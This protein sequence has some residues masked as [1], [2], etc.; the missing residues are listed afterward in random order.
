MSFKVFLNLLTVSL[1]VSCLNFGGDSSSSGSNSNNTI[2]T[3]NPKEILSTFKGGTVDIR[4]T[5][6][7]KISG[8]IDQKKLLETQ[9]TLLGNG[10][11][12]LSSDKAVSFIGDGKKIILGAR[13]FSHF[14]VEEYRS[15]KSIKSII[16]N[17]SGGLE[18]RLKL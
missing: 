2:P 5:N 12:I 1:F 6:T 16:K 7:L 4:N 9:I 11:V 3:T 14:V 18:Y 15:G 10:K 13:N 8:T 17:S